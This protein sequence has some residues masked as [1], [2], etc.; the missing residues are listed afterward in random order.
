[1][2]VT[3][4]IGFSKVENPPHSDTDS[5]VCTLEHVCALSHTL[6]APCLSRGSFRNAHC[7][8]QAPCRCWKAYPP[9][10]LWALQPDHPAGALPTYVPI[11]PAIQRRQPQG[12]PLVSCDG[13]PSPLAAQVGQWCLSRGSEG[14]VESGSSVPC[15]QALLPGG[16][17]S[18]E[19]LETGVG[20]RACASAL[21][22]SCSGQC[23]TYNRWLLLLVFFS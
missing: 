5:P 19:P 22:F 17:G 8:V 3:I 20:R 14:E 1:M 21:S 9:S 23:Q 6:W 2:S 18:S 13:V 4:E 15:P 11:H 10:P 12:H 16:C 7:R